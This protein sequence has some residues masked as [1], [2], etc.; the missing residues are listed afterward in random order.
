MQSF[1][2]TARD[3]KGQNVTGLITADSRSD[4]MALLTDRS[5][6]PMSVEPATKKSGVTFAFGGR[7]STELLAATLTQLS[8]L[9]SNGVPLLQGLEIL[10]QQSPG[11]RMQSVLSDIRSRVSEG[12]QLH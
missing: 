12:Q 2:Y 3:M 5:L 9:L 4:V 6:F 10:I 1:A 7:S 11:E 8:D